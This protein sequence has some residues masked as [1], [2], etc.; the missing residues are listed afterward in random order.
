VVTD[1]FCKLSRKHRLSGHYRWGR[2][3]FLI[4]FVSKVKDG[5][6]DN[7]DVPVRHR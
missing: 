6:S 7:G 3:A 5:S 2:F 1:F 4:R